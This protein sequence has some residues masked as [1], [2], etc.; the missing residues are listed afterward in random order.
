[1]VKIYFG[2]TSSTEEKE[3]MRS[4]QESQGG[5][6]TQEVILVQSTIYS[7]EMKAEIRSGAKIK[8]NT[9]TSGVVT[10]EIPYTEVVKS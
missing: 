2:V 8:R 5:L 6:P 10:A 3:M 7:T 1:M 9:S 4:Q